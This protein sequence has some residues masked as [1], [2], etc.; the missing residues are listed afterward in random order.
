MY[1]DYFVNFDAEDLFLHGAF[2]DPTCQR[3]RI[4]T[5][6]ISRLSG[7][8]P[9]VGPSGF[10]L[11]WSRGYKT[12]FML[13]SVENEILNANKY[14]N[15]RKFSVFFSGSDKPRMLFFLL[16]KIQMPTIVGILTFMSRKNF[17]LN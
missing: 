11:P 14:K 17:M 13:T 9:S 1:D 7:F 4:F 15:I 3:H 6:K 16:I 10:L 12:F 2:Q 5:G 8:L